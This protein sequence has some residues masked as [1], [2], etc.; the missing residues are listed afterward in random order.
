MQYANFVWNS[1]LPSKPRYKRD[2][3]NPSCFCFVERYSEAGRRSVTLHP[4][5]LP[6]GFQCWM[7]ADRYGHGKR[8]TFVLH[9]DSTS[10][11]TILPFQIS[12]SRFVKLDTNSRMDLCGSRIIG[13]IKWKGSLK[14]DIKYLWY[15]FV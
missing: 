3:E 1:F 13:K 7:T 15:N 2:N 8:I 6:A 5:S 12:R 11:F 9:F 14:K 4:V 10:S